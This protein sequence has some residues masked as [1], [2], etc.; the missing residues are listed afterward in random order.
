MSLDLFKTAYYSSFL[1]IEY[2]AL[3]PQHIKIV[4]SFWDKQNH[5][6]AFFT[7]YVLLS[8]AY[9]HLSTRL[10]VILLLLV[11]F[12]IEITQYFIPNRF[13]SLMDIVA[14]C[15][16]IVIGIGIYKLITKIKT[17]L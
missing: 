16:G 1:A 15:I 17:P 4:A 6:I 12:Q 14:D 13:F 3:T 7:L 5:F 10:K 2:L 9:K 8:L 11:G